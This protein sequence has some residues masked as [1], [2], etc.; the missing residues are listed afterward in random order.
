MIKK[1]ANKQKI[2]LNESQGEDVRKLWLEKP[3]FSTDDHQ[4]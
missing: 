3:D 4:K 1:K 2:S